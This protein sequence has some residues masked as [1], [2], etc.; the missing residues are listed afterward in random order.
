M[1]PVLD[2][3]LHHQTALGTKRHHRWKK[4]EGLD[5]RVV[6]VVPELV[7]GDEGARSANSGTAV[8][9]QGTLAGFLGRNG[10]GS[11]I[12]NSEFNQ[13]VSTS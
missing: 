2:A 13:K 4:G 12:L 5:L 10:F 7:E 6:V 9:Q 3:L 1:I 8:D 11:N